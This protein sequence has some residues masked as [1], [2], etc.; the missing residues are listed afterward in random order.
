MQDAEAA[1]GQTVLVVDDEEMLVELVC[2]MVQRRG[3]ETVTATNAVDALRLYE[4]RSPEI[5]LV[6]TDLMMPGMDGRAL[7][8]ELLKRNPNV[9]ILVSTGY[10][11]PNDLSDVEAMGIKG[12]V[13]KPYQSDQLL[14]MVDRALAD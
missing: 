4:E 2:R 5:R 7:T 3:F 8:A 13:T 9:R 11:A 10:S 1:G 12:V 14:E 6:I